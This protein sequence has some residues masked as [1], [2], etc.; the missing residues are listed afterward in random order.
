[1]FKNIQ[2]G[3]NFD[4][5]YAAFR[6]PTSDPRPPYG[7]TTPS[8]LSLL[9]VRSLINRQF[10]FYFGQF[11]GIMMSR[12]E[13]AWP[14]SDDVDHAGGNFSSRCFVLRKAILRSR[15][16]NELLAL[17]SFCVWVSRKLIKAMSD[18]L[19]AGALEKGLVSHEVDWVF[20]R[21]FWI[22]ALDNFAYFFKISDCLC[23]SLMMH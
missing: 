12:K 16:R 6:S 19:L 5:V 1:M 15:I 3:P 9:F 20:R 4:D 7:H 22:I 11:L 2:R 18:P 8:T 10:V 14:Q 17:F 21:I 13:L 23:D